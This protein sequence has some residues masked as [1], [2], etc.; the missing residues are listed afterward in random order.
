MTLTEINQ[1]LVKLSREAQQ[2]D[3]AASE[4][5]RS[6]EVA[7]GRAKKLKERSDSVQRKLATHA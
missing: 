6:V 7:R 2:T 5:R 3:V 4:L 1:K